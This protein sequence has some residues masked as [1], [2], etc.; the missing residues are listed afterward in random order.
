MARC[1]KYGSN[2]LSRDGLD[3]TIFWLARY[4][5]R[6]NHGTGNETFTAHFFTAGQTLER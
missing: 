1:R 3:R 4:L 6:L 5:Y 2:E